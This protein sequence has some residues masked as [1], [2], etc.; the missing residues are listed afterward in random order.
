MLRLGL[1]ILKFVSKKPWTKPRHN[2]Y[3]CDP[4]FGISNVS[5]KVLN[6]EVENLSLRQFKGNKERKYFLYE[7]SLKFNKQKKKI[8]KEFE[9]VLYVM[10]FTE[11]LKLMLITID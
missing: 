8:T 2:F 10:I 3:K 6:A 4:G 7:L 9:D 5:S 11:T 1:F